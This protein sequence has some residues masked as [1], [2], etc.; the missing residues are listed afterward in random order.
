M[1]TTSIPGSIK[2]PATMSSS[3]CRLA[4]LALCPCEMTTAIRFIFLLVHLSL[5]RPLRDLPHAGQM[6]NVTRRLEQ[7]VAGAGDFKQPSGAVLVQVDRARIGKQLLIESHQSPSNRRVQAALR[8]FAVDR[9][10]R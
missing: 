2:R 4:G 7:R 1:T 8:L 6:I 9:A 5:D 10:G 3:S